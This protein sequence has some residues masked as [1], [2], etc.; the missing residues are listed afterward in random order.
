M[1]PAGRAGCSSLAVALFLAAP[2][3]IVAGVSVNAAE[4]AATFR[5]WAFRSPGT[6]QIFA[7]P[8]WRNALLTSV[9]DRGARR[10]RSPC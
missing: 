6:A 5:R 7:D 10:R 8:G 4:D 1:T 2:I 9:V 3:V